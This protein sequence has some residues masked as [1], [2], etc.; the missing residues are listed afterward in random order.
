MGIFG[1]MAQMP[2]GI[3]NCGRTVGAEKLMK[4]CLGL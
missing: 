4:L 3:T 1:N 2:G